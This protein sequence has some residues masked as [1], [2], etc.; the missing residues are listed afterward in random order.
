MYPLIMNKVFNEPWLIDVKTHHAIQQTLINRIQGSDTKLMFG[1]SPKSEEPKPYQVVGSTA[2]INMFGVVGKH[3][4]GLEMACGGLSL[5][6]SQML[7][8]MADSDPKVTNT[9]L[10]FNS[11]GGTVTGVYEAGKAITELNKP[12]YA[13]TETQMCSA[14]YWL[15]S[16]CDSIITT[17]SAC[18]GSIGVYMALM[19]YSE[20]MQKEGVKLDLIKSGEFKAMGIKPLTEDERAILQERVEAIHDQFKTE[21]NEKRSVSSEYM[22]GLT[23]TG[24]ESVENGLADALV[25]SIS[26]ALE[27]ISG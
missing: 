3:L 16:K 1:E 14:A 12:V 25:F 9:L 20:K 4:S 24:E 22:E 15:G 21:V 23:Y 5:D 18:L 11:P 26:E 6:S 8:K 13:F 10:H 17:P 19:D 27:I 7:M 2:V